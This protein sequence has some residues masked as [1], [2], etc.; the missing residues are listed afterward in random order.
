VIPTVDLE[1]AD[2]PAMLDT[3]AR[4]IGMFQLIGHGVDVA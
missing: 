1:A 3:A 4:T 2:S